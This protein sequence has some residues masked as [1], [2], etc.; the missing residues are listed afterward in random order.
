[1]Q[2]PGQQIFKIKTLAEDDSML[3]KCHKTLDLIEPNIQITLWHNNSLSS[4]KLVVACS[5]SKMMS[6]WTNISSSLIISIERK[7]F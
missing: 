7:A 5:S 6:L 4:K 2:S 3:I 1:M